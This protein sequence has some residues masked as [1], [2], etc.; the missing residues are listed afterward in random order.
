[1]LPIDAQ[2]Y[3]LLTTGT[4][5]TSAISAPCSILGY[6]IFQEKIDSRIIL[7]DGANIISQ[8][9]AV[10]TPYIALNHICAGNITIEKSLGPNPAFITINYLPYSRST[11]TIP[12]FTYGEAI[13]SFFLF[14]IF[15][16]AVFSFLAIRYLGI[17]I[18]K[19][20]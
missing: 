16:V 14:M 19:G 18:K 12:A 8:S 13:N 15:M 7:K 6:Q 20:V 3:F 17:K 10:N 4:S 11:T 1:M 9:Y 5:T 2:T